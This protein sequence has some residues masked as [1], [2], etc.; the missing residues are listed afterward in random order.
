MAVV[1]I[2]CPR[3]SSASQTATLALRFWARVDKSGDCWLWKGSVNR[4]GYGRI[5]INRTPAYAHRVAYE[6]A[7]GPIPPGMQIDHLCWTT[8]CVRPEHLRVLS[9]FE[10]NSRRKPRVAQTLESMVASDPIPGVAW[11]S[12]RQ[13][14]KVSLRR[15]EKYYWGGRFASLEDANAACRKLYD[16]VDGRA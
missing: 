5:T 3:C 12:H 10:N 14:W 1:Q 16:D 6:L 9:P 8:G 11:Q 4:S 7:V 2:I 15:G 13:K